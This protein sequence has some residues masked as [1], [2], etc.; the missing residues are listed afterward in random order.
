MHAT[1]KVTD[2]TFEQDVLKSDKPVLV[3][4]WASWCPPCLAIAPI[5]EEFAG[6][7]AD[8][9]TVAKL[10]TEENHIIPAKYQIRSIP[11]MLLFQDGEV[12]KTLIGFTSK[13]GLESEFADFLKVAK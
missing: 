13:M 10:S 4:F 3:D 2:A 6:E 9:I 7:H 11:T 8:S 12:K 5:L 1:K